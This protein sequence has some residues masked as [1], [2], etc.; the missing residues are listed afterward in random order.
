MNYAVDVT[1]IIDALFGGYG[2]RAGSFVAMGELGYGAVAP[3]AYDPAKARQLLA[4]AG[5]ANGFSMDMACPA[6][7]YGS[8][9][10]VCK[11]V[12]FY[13]QEVGI[14]IDLEIMESTAFWDLEAKKEL[15]PLFGDSWGSSGREAYDRLVGAL[16]G[17][18]ASYSSWADPVVLDLLDRIGS[19][20]D[21]D[22]RARLY[23]EL[24]VYMQENP[25]FI[26][27]YEPVTFEAINRRVQNYHPLGGEDYWLFDTW[28]MTD[29]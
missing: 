28:L 4:D 18:E 16:G 14:S 12:A 6:G 11:A 21:Q 17:Q 3:F 23:E 10:E 13:L 9:E 2:K 26:Y 5:Y 7:A 20:P 1:A 29:E 19:T 27:L 15:P 8:F 24:Q 25:P 22:S